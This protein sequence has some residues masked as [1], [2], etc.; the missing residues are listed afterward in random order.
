[1]DAKTLEQLINLEQPA[2]PLV[3]EW[4]EQASNQVEV[5]P[6]TLEAREA[7]LLGTQV[8]TRSPMGAIVFE[9]GGLLVDHGWIRILGA[10]CERMPRSLPLWNKAATDSAPGEGPF[11]LI[12]DDVTGGFFALDN[13]GISGKPGQVSYFSPTELEWQDL[14]LSYSEFV[15]F[16]LN[17]DLSEFYQGMRWDGW[18]EE[19]QKVRGDNAFNVYPPPY[20]ETIPYGK[21]NRKAVPLKELYKFIVVDSPNQIRKMGLKPGQEVKVEIKSSRN[22]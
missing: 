10:E 6:A 15:L 9:T 22:Q 1:M 3:K 12:G 13:G 4:I 19:V 8:T 21:R 16:C 17:G 18:Q 7:A 14:D 11:L 2:W 5:L 20:T